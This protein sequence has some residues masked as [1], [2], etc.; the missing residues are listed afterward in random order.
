MSETDERELR[1][2]LSE[3]EEIGVCVARAAKDGKL[4]TDNAVQ[5]IL[6]AVGT[7]TVLCAKSIELQERNRA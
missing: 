2:V 6:A 3:A 5:L 4:P 7:I 1:K